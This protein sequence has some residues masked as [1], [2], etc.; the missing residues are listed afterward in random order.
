MQQLYFPD[1][2]TAIVFAF[3]IQ[4]VVLTVFVHFSW[5]CLLKF[6]WSRRHLIYLSA[7]GTRVLVSA[8]TTAGAS[9]E[10]A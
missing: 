5:L 1:L 10:A 8:S 6:D 3:Q 2:S 7:L 4:I 9:L